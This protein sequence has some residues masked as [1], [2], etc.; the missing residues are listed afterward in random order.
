MVRAAWTIGSQRGTSAASEKISYA[1]PALA[2]SV[3]DTSLVS[4][5]EGLAYAATVTMSVLSSSQPEQPR[6]QRCST[7]FHAVG[8]ASVRFQLADRLATEPTV[9][10]SRGRRSPYPRYA[11]AASRD[12]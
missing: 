6:Y 2:V 11:A 12:R 7:R 1:T 10:V 3:V 4:G 5:E 8:A 9:S